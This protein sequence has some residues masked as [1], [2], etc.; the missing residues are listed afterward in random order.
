MTTTPIGVP[1]PGHPRYRITEDARVFGTRGELKPFL[2]RG[3]P[4]I[5]TSNPKETIYLA[6]T[7][8]R[9]FLGPPQDGEKL[10]Y[11]DGD[12]H[13][14]RVN[15]LF[16]E[17]AAPVH[18]T[19]WWWSEKPTALEKEYARI[20]REKFRIEKLMRQPASTAWGSPDHYSPGC[21]G[22]KINTKG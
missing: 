14:W 10:A 3:C 7:A 8:S 5:S 18:S 22:F 20:R 1:I 21:I 6:S 15:N 4:A 2:V 9:L 13:N 16:Y 19:A 12:P 11:K 17:T